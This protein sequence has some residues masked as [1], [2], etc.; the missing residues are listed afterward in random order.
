MSD[1]WR[2]K[3]VVI[4]AYQFNDRL[5]DP[6]PSWLTQAIIASQVWYHGGDEPYLTIS[7]LEG[8]MRADLGAWVIRG[9]KGELYP[10]RDDIFRMTYEPDT[11]AEAA[12]VSDTLRHENDC[13]QARIAAGPWECFRDPSYYDMWLVRRVDDRAFGAGFHLINGDEA[14]A[15][16]DLLNQK[17]PNQ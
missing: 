4:E 17:E 11:Q 7:T 8:E 10:C 2:K 16:R 1:R 5:N 15:L 9:V 6:M 14:A 13:L 12:P 3:P